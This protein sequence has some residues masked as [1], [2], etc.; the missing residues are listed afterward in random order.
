MDTQKLLPYFIVSSIIYI[1]LDIYFIKSWFNFVKRRKLKPAFFYSILFT[2]IFQLLI[3]VYI[4]WIRWNNQ[5]PNNFEKILFIISSIW[6]L[7][8]LIITPVLFIKDIIIFTKNLFIKPSEINYE[9]RKILTNIGWGLASTPFFIITHGLLKTTNN[10]QV[11]YVD[12]PINNLNP[13][14]DGFRIVQISDIHAG[15]FFSPD[16]FKRARTITEFLNPD[17]ITMTGDF[18]NFNHNEI[19]LIYK[20]LSSFRAEYGIYGCLGN[21]E[22]YMIKEEMK[23]LINKLNHAGINL[24]INSNSIIDVRNTKLNLAGVDN[25]SYRHNFA[26]FNKAISGLS[27]DNPTIL[28]CHDPSNWKKSI[29]K[30][31]N[32]ELTLSGHTHGGQIGIELGGKELSPVSV[33]YDEWAGLYSKNDQYLYVNRGLGVASPPVRIGIEPEIT[34][35]TLKQSSNIT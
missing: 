26:D 10:Q 1:L 18:V 14:L 25:T 6:Y 15:S 33:F 21:H 27:N 11:H 12:I 8:K 28:L 9:R 4:V 17:I 31:I 19:D 7:P 13:A 24:L 22:H 2:G 34:L 3:N 29:L 30:K 32:V 5:L 35:I 20:E 16:A 23:V